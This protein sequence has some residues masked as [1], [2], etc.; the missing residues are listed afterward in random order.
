MPEAAAEKKGLILKH[1]GTQS[2]TKNNG[3]QNN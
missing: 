2:E 1:M 3:I